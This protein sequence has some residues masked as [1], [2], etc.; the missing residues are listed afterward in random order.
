MER[1]V[2]G[3][4]RKRGGEVPRPADPRRAPGDEPRPLVPDVL[5]GESSDWGFAGLL[6]F[7]AVLFLRPQD[8]LPFL[9]P[10]HLAEATAT[11][12]LLA[13]ISKRLARGEPIIRVTPEVLALLAFGA[14]LVVTTPFS[15]WP[16]GS[17][18]IITGMYVKVVLIVILMVNA[19]DSPRRLQ[20]F[21]WLVVLASAYLSFRAVL[22]YARGVNLVEGGRVAGVV[23]GIFG[24]PNDLALNLVAFLPFAL[25]FALTGRQRARAEH[26]A[27]E[28]KVVPFDRRPAWQRRWRASRTPARA[29]VGPPSSFAR[30]VAAGCAL[31]MMLAIVFTKSRSGALGFVGMVVVLIYFGRRLR[32]GLGIATVVG[33]LV[34][35]P[36]LPGSFWM[37]MSSIVEADR[38]TTGSRTTR[39][40][41]MGEAWRVFLERPLTGVGPGQFKN[42]NP[43]WREERW[44]E[45]HDVWLQVA[46]DTGLIGLVPF[47][48]LVVVAFSAALEP[49]R[50]LD[51]LLN[52][53]KRRGP[54]QSSPRADRAPP[55]AVPGTRRPEL[56]VLYLHAVALVA[57]LAGWAVCAVFASVAYNW[58]FYY[59]LG[60]AVAT[61]N[62]ARSR[63]APLEAAAAAPRLKRS[64]GA[65]F[66][67]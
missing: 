52:P 50:R 24:N 22:D 49:R 32:P 7:T 44:S 23:A 55:E 53:R 11:L 19:I 13:M 6:A 9:T 64:A 57:A 47:V 54:Q 42:Y 63:L 41:V 65:T 4:G 25:L 61:R 33:V 45:A 60:L 38:D 39:R 17:V 29:T 21:T 14:A 40:E 48:A 1:L 34:L 2:F 37:R 31:M 18:A 16:G 58:T 3:Y 56:R 43:S 35:T 20:R 66:A 51:R 59:L 27:P 10:L 67:K 12:G 15:Y 8:Q 26:A 28:G 62:L 5:P 46:S 30:L 36:F